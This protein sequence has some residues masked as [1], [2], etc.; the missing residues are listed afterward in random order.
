MPLRRLLHPIR[1]LSEQGK[2]AGLLLIAATAVSLLVSNS[3]VGPAYRAFWETEVGYGLLQKSLAHWVNDGLM[4]IF[5]LL[6][7]LE[8]K[9]EVLYGELAQPRQAL[10]PALAALGGVAVPA[11]LFLS[12]TRGTAASAGWAIPTA[13][14]IAFSLGILSLLGN[15]VPFGL[16]VFLTALAIIDDLLAVII[17]AVFYSAGLHVLYLLAAAGVFALLLLLNR[18]RVRRLAP[19]LLLGLLLWFCVLESGIHATI[20]G[21]LLAL[22]IPVGRLERLEHALQRPVNYLVLPLFALCNTAIVL[23]GNVGASLASPLAWGVGAGL[24]LGKPLGIVG[25]TAG[26]VR[27]GWGEL[28]VGVSWRRFIGLGFTAGIG[29]TMAIFIATL[30]FQQPAEVDVAKLAVLLGSAASAV[31]GILILAPGRPP[32]L[33]RPDDGAEA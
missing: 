26:L 15:R 2:L 28:P 14:D 24:L 21:V 11:L 10:V 23:T 22:A 30:S 32:E 29:F 27:L 20:A 16:R 13:T 4:A 1:E 17:I 25:V 33:E 6:V 9:R 5:F 7:G 8:I 19:Y 3:G 31:V 18:L 12:F